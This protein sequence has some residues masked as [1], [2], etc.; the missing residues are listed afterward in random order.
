MD[1]T[2][3]WTRRL[4]TAGALLGLLAVLFVSTGCSRDG[5][6]STREPDKGKA[7]KKAS[8]PIPVEVAPATLGEV[9]MTLDSFASIESEQQA[10][11]YA[12]ADGQV[13]AL[14]AE[15]GDIVREGQLLAQL[16]PEDRAIQLETARLRAENARKELER[17]EATYQQ[18]MISDQDYDKLKSTAD[19]AAQELKEAEWRLA[20]T[21]VV[22][23]F[24]GKITERKIVLGKTVKPG[25]HL[26]TIASY[27]PLVARVFLPQKD[28]ATLKIGQK[29]TLVPES[30]P[31]E[32]WEGEVYR[33]SPVI[34]S[35]TGTVKVTVKLTPQSSSVEPRPGTYVRVQI[36]VASRS[37]A[38]KVP[39][40]AIF[41]ESQKSYVFVALNSKALKREVLLGYA[42]N[43]SIEVVKGVA[44]GEKVVVDGMASLKENSDLDVLKS[45]EKVA[46]ETR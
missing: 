13:G 46:H 4:L 36:R 6:G 9:F 18:K 1:H 32:K 43:G 40:K 34:D 2:R 31:S 26:F 16:I 28:L 37:N 45:S 21:K 10:E 7:E 24:S 35:R 11:I 25:E 42:S 12:K 41:E 19:I 8:A 39:K 33:I 30:S 14:R 17:A 5:E 29:A 23:P 44:A 27:D 20:N 3:D 22:A 15:E 38:V